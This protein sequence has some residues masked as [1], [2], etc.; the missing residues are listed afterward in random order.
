MIDEID[1][2]KCTGCKMCADICNFEAI[3]FISDKEGFWYPEVD[4]DKCTKCGVCIS[5]CPIMNKGGSNKLMPKVYAAWSNNTDI[6]IQS[7][8]GAI[9]YELANRMIS[10]GGYISGA[11]YTTD[12]KGA[13]HVVS[14]SYEGLKEIMG[15]K[16]FQSDTSGVFKKIKMLLENDQRVLFCGTPCHNAALSKYLIKNYDNLIQCD[17]ICR[18]VNSPKAYRRFIE[19][20]EEKFG[21]EIDLVHF[22]SKKK[23]WNRFGTYIE[24]KNGKAYFKDRYNC[25]FVRGYIEGNLYMRPSCYDC[26]FKDLPRVS[27]IT[28]GD[29]W[30]VRQQ[31]EHL[32]QDMGT[33]VV[34]INSKKGDELFEAIKGNIC[35]FK[36]SIDAVR[37][38]NSC[39]LYSAKEGKNRTIFFENIDLM[40]FDKLVKKLCKKKF[41]SNYI[42]GLKRKI[43][44]FK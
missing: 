16:Y 12:F 1:K 25:P 44:S 36:Q 27:D 39:L 38:G 34:L 8:S 3:S 37:K 6:R 24:F 22:K 7:T 13:E 21:S 28:M 4:Y 31:G 23:G 10:E 17:F 2:K 32:D 29:F 42:S 18:G 20:L 14:N 35:Y 11:K 33:S 5:F 40:A 19:T 43:S 41:P 30:G 26:Q 9:Y 15:S